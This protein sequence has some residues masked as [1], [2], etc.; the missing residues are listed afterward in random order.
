MADQVDYRIEGEDLQSVSIILDPGEGMRAEPGAM[1]WMEDGI[2]MDTST[3]G[4]LFS[5]LKRK[6]AGES[7]FITSF[8]NG[9]NDRREVTYGGPYP[10]CIVPMDLS[11]GDILCQRDAYLCSANGIEVTLGFT[12]R[13][14]AGLLGGEGFILQRLSGDGWAFVHAGGFVIE[15]ELGP[16]ESLR[17]DTGCIAAFEETVDYDIRMVKGFKSMLFGGEGLFLA[18]LKGP[19]KVWLQTMPFSRLARRIGGAIGIGQ[20]ET[21]RGGLSMLGDMLGGD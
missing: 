13:L 1:L 15:R 16:G 5:G 12:K 14:G 9:A 10:G 19:G 17:V 8:T 3:G 18:Y 2:E 7:F 4:G 11:R 20:G 6:I 21:R